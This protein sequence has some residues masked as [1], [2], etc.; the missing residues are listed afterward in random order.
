MKVAAKKIWYECERCLGEC[1]DRGQDGKREKPRPLTIS[2]TKMC[3]VH[4]QDNRH[5][6]AIHSKPNTS[7]IEKDIKTHN[8]L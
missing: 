4:L 8:S 7:G 1:D 3:F 2:G 5:I 6:A